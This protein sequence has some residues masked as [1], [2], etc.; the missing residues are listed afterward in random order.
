M[1]VDIVFDTFVELDAFLDQTVQRPRREATKASWSSRSRLS[2][3]ALFETQ[4][5]SAV[6]SAS[7]VMIF[8]QSYGDFNGRAAS[9]CAAT[10]ITTR[11]AAGA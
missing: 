10:P 8:T 7:G 6:I 2:A 9:A 5:F 3:V 4:A 11:R 1:D